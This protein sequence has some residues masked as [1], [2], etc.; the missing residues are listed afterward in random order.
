MDSKDEV[1]DANLKTREQTQFALAVQTNAKG[2]SA[3][4]ES[5]VLTEILNST[6]TKAQPIPERDAEFSV[7]CE[8]LAEGALDA[9]VQRVVDEIG[10]RIAVFDR[11]NASECTMREFISP[12]LIGAVKLMQNQKKKQYLLQLICELPVAGLLCSGP[13][14]YSIIYDKLSIILTEAKSRD[15]KK[16]LIQN[17]AQQRAALEF[18]TNFLIASFGAKRKLEF[19]EKF[20]EIAKHPSFGIVTTGEK[21]VFTK[22]VYDAT[23]TKTSIVQSSVTEVSLAEEHDR[24]G[25]IR[26]LLSTI[27][28][29]IH[30]QMQNVNDNVIEL[31]QKRRILEKEVT[32]GAAALQEL[33]DSQSDY[34]EE[35]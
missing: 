11:T 5:E 18:T 34:I 21:W 17:L 10:I 6:F 25:A 33:E 30:S 27:A 9:E 4:N 14:D 24:T 7:K 13:V 1:S 26:K 20:P 15:I 2:F 29:I 35:T 23:S 3:L 22:C 12:I 8:F 32:F 19:A 31:A 28:A 16:G